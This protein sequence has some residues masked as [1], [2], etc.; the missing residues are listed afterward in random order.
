MEAHDFFVLLGLAEVT[1]GDKAPDNGSGA[2]R[3]A[4]I[5]YSQAIATD[6]AC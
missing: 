4:F 3:A 6:A 1:G 2:K 5:A